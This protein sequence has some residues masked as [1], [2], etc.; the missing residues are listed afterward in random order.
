M[1]T[2]ELQRQISEIV[3]CYSEDEDIT[4]MSVVICVDGVEY[5]IDEIRTELDEDGITQVVL[6]V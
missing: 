5:P 3:D 4:A 6:N 2:L 1:T